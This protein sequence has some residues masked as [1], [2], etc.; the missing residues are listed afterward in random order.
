[1]ACGKDILNTFL[2]FSGETSIAGINNAGKKKSW[3]RSGVWLVI[4]LV[5]ICLTGQNVYKI[6]LDYYKYPVTT[7]TDML[8]QASILLPAVT[9]CS[10][11]RVHCHNAVATL[12]QMKTSL[13]TSS[14]LSGSAR[15][16][17]ERELKVVSQMVAAEVT[18]CL[19]TFCVAMK[20]RLGKVFIPANIDKLMPQL[21]AWDQLCP[22]YQYKESFFSSI[23]Y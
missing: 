12:L 2:E 14:G 16:E 5:F 6:G 9:V 17:V 10:L 4:F 11:N 20:K 22:I 21:R 19:P 23:Y 13:N 18:D 3:L 7:S 15:A 8:D 1:M